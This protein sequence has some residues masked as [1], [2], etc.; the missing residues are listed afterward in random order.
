MACSITFGAIDIFAKAATVFS[1]ITIARHSTWGNPVLRAG[2]TNTNAFGSQAVEGSWIHT[3]SASL[4]GESSFSGIKVEGD[5]LPQGRYHIPQI[6]VAG[7]SI[8]ISPGWGG[9]YAQ[10]NY[11]T[12]R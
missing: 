6:D 3:F 9:A 1:E 8:G 5:N 7:Q 10:H 2:M 12:K 11:M 4:T